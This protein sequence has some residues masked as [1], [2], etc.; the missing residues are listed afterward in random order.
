MF[1]QITKLRSRAINRS[2]GEIFEFKV[3]SSY[4]Q[5]FGTTGTGKGKIVRLH[6]M[7]PYR[8]AEV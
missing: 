5:R 7:K 4:S 8:E 2:C 6:A 3:A 1:S